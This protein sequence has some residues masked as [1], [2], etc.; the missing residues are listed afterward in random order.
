[1]K[2]WKPNEE[3]YYC[4]IYFDRHGNYSHTKYDN[5]DLKKFL[6]SFKIEMATRCPHSGFTSVRI[7]DKWYIF[8]TDDVSDNNTY[9][10]EAIQRANLTYK[11]EMTIV[12]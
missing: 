12:K 3:K 9:M 1:M 6:K 8:F 11:Y 10:S 5:D 7:Y 4:M 2:V